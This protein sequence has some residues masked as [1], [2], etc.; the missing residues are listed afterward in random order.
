MAHDPLNTPKS[1]NQAEGRVRYHFIKSNFFRVVLAEGVY[2]GISPSGQIRMTFFNE[3][4]ALPQQTEYGINSDGSLGNE[5]PEGRV[6]RDG[7]VRELEV[8][9]V[10]NIEHARLVHQ[11]LGQKIEMLAKIKSDIA[12]SGQKDVS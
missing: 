7:F 2:G 11:W 10:M 12:E 3:R 4:S 9:V 5:D 8:D 1:T 6:S